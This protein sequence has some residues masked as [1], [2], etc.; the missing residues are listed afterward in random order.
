M[1]H[2]HELYYV[3]V[4]FGCLIFPIAAPFYMATR[5]SLTYVS[6]R[7][8]RLIIAFHHAGWYDERLSRTIDYLEIKPGTRVLEVGCGTGELSKRLLSAG[9]ELTAIDIN[10]HFISKLKHLP[11]CFELRSV[12]DL[13]WEDRFDR[14]VMLDVLHHICD[15]REAVARMKKALK[16]GGF[17]VIWEGS[18]GMGEQE[19][20]KN[21]RSFI[22]RVFDGDTAEFSM[23]DRVKEF[24]MAS[25]EPFCYVMRK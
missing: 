16:P 10:E 2:K 12:L 5:N 23:E 24:K 25:P 3:G 14:V 7:L 6:S 4:I 19:L 21:M 1:G 22:M 17:A 9:A 11:G 15:N 13:D 20:P 8:Y 18:K